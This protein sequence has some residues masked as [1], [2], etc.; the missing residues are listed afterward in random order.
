MIT[1]LR[2]LVTIDI[3][4]NWFTISTLVIAELI[5]AAHIKSN[6]NQLWISEFNENGSK[7]NEWISI[8]MVINQMIEEILIV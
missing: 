4:F 6:F 5:L 1:I 2:K 7:V 8:K 3:R